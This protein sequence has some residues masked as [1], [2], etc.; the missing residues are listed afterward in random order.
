MLTEKF[1]LS[2]DISCLYL[3][4]EDET[5]FTVEATYLVSESVGIDQGYGIASD[6]NTLN[7]GVRFEF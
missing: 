6:V 3:G 4:D 7:L 2:A 1:E 5:T